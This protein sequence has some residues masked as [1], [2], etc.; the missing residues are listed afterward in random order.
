METPL[1][2]YPIFNNNIE[3]FINLGFPLHFFSGEHIQATM[4]EAS[5]IPLDL[6]WVNSSQVNLYSVKETCANIMRRRCVKGANQAAWQLRAITCIDLTTLAGDDTTS[7]VF[8]LG[9]CL[10]CSI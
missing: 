7:N 6:D 3:P 8:R 4:V 9:F 1:A 2:S 5:S 10:K